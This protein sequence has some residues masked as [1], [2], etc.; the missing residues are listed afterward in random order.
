[1]RKCAALNNIIYLGALVKADVKFFGN[2]FNTAA[3]KAEQAGYEVLAKDVDES[4]LTLGFKTSAD[5]VGRSKQIAKAKIEADFPEIET[6]TTKS[7]TVSKKKQA[8]VMSAEAKYIF[9]VAYDYTGTDGANVTNILNK[10]DRNSDIFTQFNEQKDESGYR[11][12]VLVSADSSEKAEYALGSVLTNTTVYRSGTPTKMEV[13][14]DMTKYLNK[15]VE[16]TRI[17]TDRASR[18]AYFVHAHKQ[19]LNKMQDSLAEGLSAVNA[20]LA[21][22]ES[23][24]PEENDTEDT[25]NKKNERVAKLLKNTLEPG[26]DS[27]SL[28]SWAKFRAQR[29]ERRILREQLNDKLEPRNLRVVQD[30]KGW[31]LLSDTEKEARIKESLDNFKAELINSNENTNI[32]SIIK[33]YVTEE[34]EHKLNSVLDNIY[35]NQPTVSELIQHWNLY[36]KYESDEAPKL[37]DG[38]SVKNLSLNPET[39]PIFA[40]FVESKGVSPKGAKQLPVE[41]KTA[42]DSEIK[43]EVPETS[44]QYTEIK[45]FV[46]KFEDQTAHEKRDI[47]KLT[48]RYSKEGPYKDEV[49]DTVSYIEQIMDGKAPYFMELPISRIADPKA[50]LNVIKDYISSLQDIK[51]YVNRINNL[52]P[53][54]KEQ[55]YLLAGKD[56]ESIQDPTEKVLYDNYIT[57]FQ[58]TLD[59]EYNGETVARVLKYLPTWEQDLKNALD[60][61]ERELVESKDE[62]NKKETASTKE[63]VFDALRSAGK[64][65]PLTSQEKYKSFSKVLNISKDEFDS[66]SSE[67]KKHVEQMLG[68]LDS[69]LEDEVAEILNGDTYREVLLNSKSKTQKSQL[70]TALSHWKELTDKAKELGVDVSS[71]SANISPK[72]EGTNPN[73]VVFIRNARAFL[74]KLTNALEAGALV[75]EELTE[76][77]GK[78]VK[79]LNMATKLNERT[80]DEHLR[81]LIEEIKDTKDFIED[82]INANTALTSEDTDNSGPSERNDTEVSTELD[83]Q[84]F[85]GIEPDS[86]SDSVAYDELHRPN[87]EK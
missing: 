83:N 55:V 43:K 18:Q 84:K 56:P 13:S 54:E 14:D 22:L 47:N 59:T 77:H 62:V 45:D 67:A 73:T 39:K 9:E 30:T 33:K 23:V 60:S 82:E 4:M 36:G 86:K 25:V 52:K 87:E 17:N 44:S 24:S 64:I 15:N 6:T 34:A 35:E 41:I 65:P 80:N 49:D 10:A 81:N 31:D 19:Y 57:P 5:F 40:A 38:F 69:Y 12:V 2:Y 28:A 70:I 68:I 27:L 79:L 16:T 78:V 85:E 29:M 32:E 48:D 8:H 75:E 7:D 20:F 42:L 3:S 74:G 26:L 21:N 72:K 71:F 63:L 53:A 58:N 66:E 51:Q 1:M 50:R 61:T 11:K 37:A 46:N 76:E